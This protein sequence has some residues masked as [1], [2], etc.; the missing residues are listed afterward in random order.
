MIIMIFLKGKPGSGSPG[1][2]FSALGV[3][4]ATSVSA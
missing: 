3:D 2:R 4:Q 1:G